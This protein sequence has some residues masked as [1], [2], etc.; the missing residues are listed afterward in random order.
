MLKVDVTICMK[1]GDIFTVK[2]FLDQPSYTNWYRTDI[3]RDT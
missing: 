1:M 2:L 3:F